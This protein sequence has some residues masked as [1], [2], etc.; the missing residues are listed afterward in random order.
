MNDKPT[1]EESIKSYEIVKE[2]VNLGFPH[3]FQLESSWVVDYC[4]KA[5]DIIRKAMDIKQNQKSNKEQ[6]GE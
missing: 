4:Y 5:S 1:I 6:Q 2:L 3:N